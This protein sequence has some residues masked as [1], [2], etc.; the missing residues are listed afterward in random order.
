MPDEPDELDALT[1]GLRRMW[2]TASLSSKLGMRAAKRVLFKRKRDDV[3]VDEAL[4]SSDA[5][6]AA[7]R[8]L[9]AKMGHLKGL[10]MKAG[11][12]ASYMPGGLPPAARQ[13]LAEL[14]AHSTPMAFARIDALL[15]AELGAPTR[16][17]F[18]SFD[19]KPF[20][21]ASIG[22]VHRAIHA[23]ATVAVKVQYPGI[24]DA[25]RN[26]LRMVNV[27]A[28]LSSIGTP[29]DASGLSAELRDRLLEE[30][31]YVREADNQRLFT[32]LLGKIPGAHVPAVVGERSTRRVLTTTFVDGS[33]LAAPREQ[34]IRDR[35]GQIIF[36]ACFELM[37][38]RCIYNADPHPGNYLIGD[39]GDVTFLDFGCV[40]RFDPAMIALWRELARTI[41][42]GDRERFADRFRALGFVGR[43]RG[44]DWD[45]QWNAM[46]YLYTPFLEPEFRHHDA[47]VSKSFGILMFDN[48][49]R[50][51][52]A[53]PPA[54][55]FLN[56][57]QWGLN[58]V[59]AQLHANSRWRDIIEEILATPIDPA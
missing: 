2:S 52:L 46:R 26:D 53:M 19:D 45:Y 36:R 17:L 14:Q 10:V 20:A 27:I 56:R 40:R 50:L 37:W 39:G 1:G 48:P 15:A 49:N 6:I 8:K 58:A 33:P 16:E 43:E 13:V 28:R 55:L 41:L 18:E 5:A 30:C 12:I 57:L 7:A 54:W 23:G 42:D 21:A 3:D 11:Q 4:A 51:K 47:H 29:L 24:E 59:L 34:P 44:F 25:I 38:R 32:S 9:V 35:A 22:Q 31:D